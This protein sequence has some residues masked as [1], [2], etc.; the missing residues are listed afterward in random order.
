MRRNKN[1][2]KKN[3]QQKSIYPDK[4]LSEAE[5]LIELLKDREVKPVTRPCPFQPSCELTDISLNGRGKKNNLSSIFK[6]KFQ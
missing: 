6:N 1:K 5:L 3:K 4:H 2:S